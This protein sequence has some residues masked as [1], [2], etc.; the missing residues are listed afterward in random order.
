LLIRTLVQRRVLEGHREGP[1]GERGA[2][3]RER[4]HDARID[5]AAQVPADRYVGLEAQP[6]RRAQQLVQG[7]ERV[8][9]LGGGLGVVER[10]VAPYR[11]PPVLPP[12][13]A[14]GLE[15]A[16]PP[17]RS[18]GRARRPERED[19]VQALGIERALDLARDQQRFHLGREIEIAVPLRVIQRQDAE[20]VAREKH[21][22]GAP[23]VDRERELAVQALQHPLA[24]L[25]VSVH[26]HLG[27][28][29]GA[30]QVPAG[31]QLAAQCEV[32]E[33]LAV[34]DD[35]DAAVFVRHGLHP[36][37]Q[38]DHA[39]PGVGEA[40]PVV[41][42]QPEPVRPAVPDGG[43]HPLQQLRG[44]AH[45]A[46]A[47]DTGHTAHQEPPPPSR[48]ATPTSGTGATSNEVRW[49]GRVTARLCS[50]S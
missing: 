10:V 15:R 24:P 32:V 12:R 16:D 49:S 37:R 17:K 36:A 14:P 29:A 23:V 4:A 25:L 43:R 19:L 13:A 1:Q 34:V 35:E 7:L 20:S 31:L 47:R 22:P 8:R 46:P 38:I 21:G 39:Q 45:W 50:I 27:V 2:R 28:A 42:V 30:E 48:A 3:R 6:H 26:Q 33:D 18:A 44:H 40:H 5:A 11:E 41:D 9:R